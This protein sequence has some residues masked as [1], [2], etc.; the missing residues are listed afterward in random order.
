M[1]LQPLLLDTATISSWVS[2]MWWPVLRISGFVAA[3]PLLSQ[4]VVPGLFKIALTLGLAFLLAPMARAPA[5]LSIFSALG[6]LL[7]VKEV[8][9]GVSIGLVVQVAFEAMS[10]HGQTVAQSMGL[11]FATLVDPQHGTA[12]PVVG[13]LYTLFAYLGYLAVGGHLMLLAAL[14]NSFETVPIGSTA[15]GAGMLESVAMWGGHV[16]QA[17]MLIALPAVIALLIVNMAFGVVH[18]TT[19]Q[20]NLMGIGFP[21]TL[22]AGFVI[23]ALGFDAIMAGILNVV[24][25]AI[26]AVAEMLSAPAA[27]VP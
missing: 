1:A 22:L 6:A 5:D 4:G 15:A 19:P 7:A 11:G 10:L 16:F 27:R 23:L 13:Q 3:A 25:G 24:H 20:L 18:R 2:R 14:A 21:I 12:T 9:I 26:A 17:G 8:L